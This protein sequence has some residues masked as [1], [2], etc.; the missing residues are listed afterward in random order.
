[1][2]SELLVNLSVLYF[3]S[4]E[5]RRFGGFMRISRMSQRNVAA[6]AAT[7]TRF[8]ARNEVEFSE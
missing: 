5:F 3:A 6:E 7:W 8:F 1:M 2:G 4:S